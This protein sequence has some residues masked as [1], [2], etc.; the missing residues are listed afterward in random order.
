MTIKYEVGHELREK[1]DLDR[2]LTERYALFHDT[3]TSINEFEIHHVEWPTYTLD[4]EEIEIEYP[5]F[6]SLLNSVPDRKH[7]STGVQVI[8]WDRN[9]IAK[10][11]PIH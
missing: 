8:A 6:K 3:K 10:S 4:I 1:T 2:W 5:R 11:N 9:R 7:Y